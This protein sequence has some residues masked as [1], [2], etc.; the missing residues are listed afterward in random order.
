MAIERVP[1]EGG[2]SYSAAVAVAGPGRWVNVSGQIAPGRTVAEAASA[3]FDRIAA[4]LEPLGG[5][6]RDVVRITAYL[7]SLDE[8]SEYSR[9]RGERFGDALPAS[10]AVQV[11][12]LLSGALIEVDAIAFIAD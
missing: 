9:V 5:S 12:G 4:A 2:A 11:A 8:Y 7:T 1:S 6:L 10:A 3:C